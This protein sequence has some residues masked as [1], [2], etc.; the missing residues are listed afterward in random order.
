MVANGLGRLG[1]VVLGS[2]T[3]CTDNLLSLCRSV[4]VSDDSNH[5]V[6][7]FNFSVDAFFVESMSVHVLKLSLTFTLNL[8]N[9]WRH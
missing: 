4:L 5:C 2:I 6:R 9:I 7:D 8:A 3:I 1:R